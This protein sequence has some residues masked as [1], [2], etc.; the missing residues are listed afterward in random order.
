M[1]RFLSRRRGRN[2]QKTTQNTT[3]PERL[4]PNKHLVQCKVI[5]LDGTDLSIDLSIVV[6]LIYRLGLCPEL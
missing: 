4:I 3:A 2:V 6:L 1:L 5:L